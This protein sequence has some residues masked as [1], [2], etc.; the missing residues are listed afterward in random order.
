M[1]E[2]VSKLDKVCNKMMSDKFGK[3]I[4]LERAELISVNEQIEELKQKMSENEDNHEKL[5]N[6]W[7]VNINKFLLFVCIF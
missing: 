3:I 7:L 4:D 6:E 1:D 2:Y 5:V